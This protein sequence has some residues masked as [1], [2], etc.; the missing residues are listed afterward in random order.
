MHRTRALAPGS[1]LLSLVVLLLGACGGGGGGSGGSTQTPSVPPNTTL[2]LKLPAHGLA[3]ADLGV[4]VIEGDAD[5]EA[6]ANYYQTAR[7][8]PKANVVRVR[9]ANR[10]DEISAAEFAALKSQVDAQLPAGVQAT[11]LTWRAPSRVLGSC[12][13]SI[14]S[15]MAFGYDPKYC[16]GCADTAAS[17]YY[18][19]ESSRPFADL[20]LRPSMLLGA[21][22]LAAAKPLIDRGVSADASYPGGEG[23]LVKTNDFARN[24]RFTDWNNLPA[25]WSGQLGLNVVDNGSGPASGNTISGKSNVLFYFTGLDVIANLASNSYRPGAVGDS[26]TSWAGVLPDALGQTTVTAW[27]DAGLTGSYGTVE[28]PCN[29]PQKFSRASV[30]IDQYSRG[31]TLIEAYWKAVEWPGQGLFVG[32]PL[33]QPF[34]DAP[35]LAIVG[36]QYQVKSRALRVGANYSLQYRVSNSSNWVTLGSFTGTRG[37]AQT[38]TAPL[39]PAEATQLRWMGPC[40]NNGAQQCVLASSS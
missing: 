6:I 23:W 39:A 31:A 24:V 34:R 9:L 16:G 27:L 3:A 12:A 26:L 22:T 30:L 21:A 11:L 36:N 4:I 29:F 15:A 35:S 40:P 8:I 20:G 25:Q 19:S 28:E 37:A 17:A 7:G 2:T 32:E 14:T 13:M 18:D 33:A 1:L 5:S 10:N 38:Q